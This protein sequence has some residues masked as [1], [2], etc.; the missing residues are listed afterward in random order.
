[1]R[2]SSC[3]LGRDELLLLVLELL[4]LPVHVLQLRLRE[5]LALER[6]P[7]EVLAVRRDRLPGLCLELDDVLLELL[8]L[9]LEPLLGGDDV[10]GAALDVLEL[11]EHLLVRVVERL[12]RVL[13]PVQQLRVLGLDD[14]RRP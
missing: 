3:L 14:Q 8:L 1:M 11:L 7:R 12:G 5:R 10:G 9:Q 13:R 2:V 4:H 6:L